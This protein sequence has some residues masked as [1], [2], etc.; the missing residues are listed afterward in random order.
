M[1]KVFF[2]TREK[3]RATM[4]AHKLVDNGPDAPKGKRFARELQPVT[5]SYKSLI[6]CP[7]K[8]FAALSA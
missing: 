8:L 6:N 1:A 4:K 7:T 2:A 3:A 5:K